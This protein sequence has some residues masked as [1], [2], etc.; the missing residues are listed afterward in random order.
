MGNREQTNQSENNVIENSISRQSFLKYFGSSVVA[1]GIA[2][3]AGGYFFAGNN[4][5]KAE[6]KIN[7]ESN[8]CC[9]SK[10]YRKSNSG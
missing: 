10:D 5:A 4:E 9:N 7:H 6:S 1:G 8:S 2:G 3:A